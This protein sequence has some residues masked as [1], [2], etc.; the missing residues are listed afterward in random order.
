[1][2]IINHISIVISTRNAVGYIDKC[3]QSAIKQD[4]PD[5]GIIFIDAQSTDG[6]FE[7]A[8]RYT[9]KHGD[10]LTCIQ[11]ETRKYQGENIRIGTEMSPPNSI[12]VTLDGDD[13]FPHNDVLKRV[14][15]E[16]VEHNCWM[17]FGLYSEYPHRD[18][19]SNYMDYPLDVRQNKTFRSYRWLATHL[20]TFR[21]ELFLKIEIDDLKDPKTGDY[22][23][24]VC[25]LSFQFPML[26]MCGVDKSR[27]IKDILYVYNRENPNSD[28]L[29]DKQTAQNIENYLRGKKPYETLKE[30]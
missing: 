13:W 7:R 26:E 21:R 10:I 22:F 15:Q 1:M 2:E 12:V 3:I 16:Y 19:S 25:D 27:Y 28:H 30:L 23:E 4:Y 24:N 14:N 17:T 9:V 29:K 8:Q 18:V 5:F 6:T 11:N 20:R